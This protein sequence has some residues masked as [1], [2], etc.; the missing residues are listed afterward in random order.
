[1][2]AICSK[3]LYALIIAT[4]LVTNIFQAGYAAKLHDDPDTTAPA[5]ITNVTAVTGSAE[6]TI[7]LSWT[8]PGDD[9]AT[10]TAAAYLV[11]Y[12]NSA[13][14]D[15]T[16]WEAATVVSTGIPAPTG[17][18]A[19][20]SMT[21]TGLVPGATYYFSIRA[22]DE[23]P[24][25]AG[26]SNSPGAAAQ[27]PPPDTTA[28]AAITDLAAATGTETGSIQLTWT[29]PGDDDA[30]GTAGDYLV[31]YST[32]II[33]SQSAWDAAT[34]VSTGVPAPTEAGASQSM[35]VASLTPGATYYFAIRARDEVP[36]LGNMSNSPSAA[37]KT[38][39]PDTTAPA[40]IT[41]LVAVTGTD[42]GTIQ[43][44][45]TAPGDDEDSGTASTYII[46]YGTEPIDSQSAWDAATSVIS[47]VPAPTE[48][49]TTQSATVTGLMPGDSYH[50][51]IRTRDENFN[52]SGI[53]NDA[54]A[55]ART[56]TPLAVGTY[57][58]F[59]S[60]LFYIGAWQS[61]TTQ[62]PL[63]YYSGSYHRSANNGERVR[64]FVNG[65]R[66]AVQYPEYGAVLDV[67]VDGTLV[68]S[69]TQGDNHTVQYKKGWVSPILN[70]G[71]HM[72][73][74][75]HNG[76][77][78]YAYLDAVYVIS[79]AQCVPPAPISN[80]AATAGSSPES[81]VLTWTA[82]G[83][84]GNSGTASKYNIR[85][86]SNPIVTEDDWNNAYI[87][88]NTLT[89]KAAGQIESITVTGLT[90]L[91]A[92][93]FAVRAQDGETFPNIGGLS[94]TPSATASAPTLAAIGAY[95]YSNTTV[96]R[97]T[98]S[99]NSGDSPKIGNKVH[100]TF[101]GARISLN[102]Y[103]GTTRGIVAVH[104]DGVSIDTINQ[105]GTSSMLQSWTS[106]TLS[107][108]THVVEFIHQTGMYVGV[109]S[110]VVRGLPESIPPATISL[111]AATGTYDEQVKLTWTAPGDNDMTGT[112]SRYEIRYSRNPILTE[113]DWNNAAIYL[114]NGSSLPLPKSAGS[115]ETILVEKITPIVTHYFAIRA[116]D[117]E[118]TPN[119]SNISNSPGA[120]SKSPTPVGAAII[121]DPSLKYV[122]SWIYTA[123]GNDTNLY[124]FNG[125]DHTSSVIGNQAHTVINGNQVVL[126]YTAGSN[127]GTANMLIDGVQFA[128]I[129]EYSATTKHQ[130]L[131]TSATFPSGVHLI[132]FV[133]A[134]GEK[135]SID[136]LIVKNGPDT[137]PPARI[138]SL[139]ATFGGGNGV[140]MLGWSATG[141]DGNAGRAWRYEVR[142]SR[143]PILTEEDWNNARVYPN[144]MSP[145]AF[146]QTES[147]YVYGLT[148]TLR[149]YFAVKAYDDE[150]PA[151][152][153]AFSNVANAIAYYPT[154]VEL[155]TYNSYPSTAVKCTSSWATENKSGHYSDNT[156]LSSTTGQKCYVVFHG[157][158]VTAVFAKGPQ[159]G[160]LKAVI[161]GDIEDTINQYSADEQFQQTWTSPLLADTDYH[162][163]EFINET[164]N[165]VNLDAVTILTSDFTPPAAITNLTAAPKTIG[166]GI[167]LTW[168]APG[169]N[170]NAG[171]AK[172]YLVRMSTSPIIDDDSWNNAT[173]VT[174]NVPSPAAAGTTQSMDV[175]YNLCYGE[176]Y[177]LA[178]RTKDEVPNISPISNSS[179][180]MTKPVV[181]GDE[182]ASSNAVR[183]TGDWYTLYDTSMHSNSE[184]R[185]YTVGNSARVTYQGTGVSV[186]FAKGAIYGT[187][188]VTI[189]G[190]SVGMI[191]QY[192]EVTQSGQ[193]WNGPSQAYGLHTIEFL[194]SAGTYV[195]LDAIVVRMDVPPDAIT[196]L[197]TS[198]QNTDG[199]TMLT[200]TS[201]AAYGRTG[202][203]TYYLIRYSTS[204]IDS[205]AAWELATAVT[206]AV[207]V[208][209]PGSDQTFTV[210]G[211][212]PG[213]RYYFSVRPAY[214]YSVIVSPSIG[215]LS[216]TPGALSRG[217]TPAPAGKYDDTNPSWTYIGTWSSSTYPNGPFNNTVH[218]TTAYNNSAKI[219]IIGERFRLI[220]TKG[221]SQ[222]NID[223]YVDGSKVAS[224]N[225]NNATTLW[226][227]K[228][229]YIIPSGPGFHSLLFSHL[230]DNGLTSTQID[231][232]EVFTASDT[233]APG[234]VSN[235]SATT[236]LVSGSIILT[237]TAPGDDNNDGKAT[238]Y[239]VKYSLN[240]IT[241]TTTWNNAAAIKKN[242]PSPANAGTSQSAMIPDLS[243]GLT[244]YFAIRALDDQ[245]NVGEM[246]NSPSAS[247]KIT[248][249]GN[250]D[251]NDLN[252]IDYSR[253]WTALYNSKAVNGTYHEARS[254]KQLPHAE[255]KFTGS[256]IRLS[257]ASSPR[258]GRISVYI[259]GNFITAI[260]QYSNKVQWQ[261]NWTSPRL[262]NGIHK[263][264]LVPISGIVNLDSIQI[265]GAPDTLPPA[266]IA[267]LTAQPG[268]AVGS[269]RLSF[270][271]PGDDDMTGTATSYQVRYSPSPITDQ[272][273][274]EHATLPSSAIPGPL[275]AGTSQSFE[276]SGLM[277]NA[278]Y[279]FAIR[280]MDE[281]ENLAPLS[282][283]P[284]AKVK[285][286]GSNPIGDYE[287]G[288]PAFK[289]SGRWTV[290]NHA[291][292]SG[293]H[294]HVS[295]QTNDT[296]EFTFEG[297]QFNLKY[298]RGPG[299]GSMA[300]VVDGVLLATIKETS[301]PEQW[302]AIW[303]S[304]LL[305]YGSHTVRF[306][307]SKG[308]MVN[309]DA[310]H[311]SKTDTSAP[312]AITDLT[313]ASGSTDGSVDLSW[314]APGDD[315]S[316]G[317][318]ISY[319][320]R[321][322]SAP[323]DNQAAWNSATIVATGIPAPA[324]G[325]TNQSMTVTGLT[326]GETYYFA[327]RATDESAN[328]GEISNS[329]SAP[330]Q[331][332]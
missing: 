192:S 76:S 195:N 212:W 72:V 56:P 256:R 207:I 44:S 297:D 187:I 19:S 318:T 148:P 231:G 183:I 213:T 276:L 301:L 241:D 92:Q 15:E 12:G 268:T 239:Q 13:I 23:V 31:R 128:E 145:K 167:T 104:I 269:V 237:W 33:D 174:V 198:P 215:G 79:E 283:S 275:A 142:Y 222:R 194:H 95:N 307:H 266:A 320:I 68:G 221:P 121:D 201:P 24:N 94:N 311:I 32:T 244:Y 262:T 309:I 66:F 228:W 220:Y 154:P 284:V 177:Y 136:G 184:L 308:S 175:T 122:R 20:Q 291:N 6:G 204:P 74:L 35:T 190:S 57:D 134:S 55:L 168:T 234:T 138:T 214:K 9:D 14:E 202:H 10:G 173:P 43:L 106:P 64:F 329:P 326:P 206:N 205:E 325:G 50:F 179:S 330:A 321:Y 40:A 319:E 259:D 304:P 115:A 151:N 181:E 109:N 1:M 193:I 119:V 48:A 243:P 73:E 182:E 253:A 39:P 178:I 302:Q 98:G 261:K 274:W 306:V 313:A 126:I 232:I 279:Y 36:N 258:Y 86:S 200:W 26:L 217:L 49:G 75:V 191:D 230:G 285:A 117:D 252:T 146:G 271:A 34:P 224:I 63:Y 141:D 58:D 250:Y 280:A 197:K 209:P 144:I 147:L 30:T 218:S 225:A 81:I 152:V 77:S 282:N 172:S 299:Y 219:N 277:P 158:W 52:I 5:A 196:N 305:A 263:M 296:A 332:S 240:P 8:A 4:L 323:I 292:A 107:S 3:F 265:Y 27:T 46:R 129:N 143:N 65:I 159:Y 93:Y 103:T 17:A 18:G 87:F 210:T 161:D 2:K 160:N 96:F 25:L 223:V 317:T 170:D 22:Q 113:T 267:D 233:T 91:V 327:V 260:N 203:A 278:A 82:P 105:Y 315:D 101:N 257:Y 59:N 316:T 310:I 7:E 245:D 322:S 37:A 67:L 100:I 249:Q 235:L 166:L 251:D 156:F 112:A 80:L 242:I 328:T 97:Y 176:T 41:D 116:Y 164:G 236:G 264:R 150:E 61:T 108:G 186:V 53:S 238:Q 99:W 51:A 114:P 290:S 157:G 153:S 71:P 78:S 89:P 185:S 11:R 248:D 227:Q 254:A 169:D 163:V 140:V 331:S 226:Q 111:T 216:N 288:S 270:T 135:I 131:W 155:G 314:T 139:T 120:I 69:I 162:V 289:Y 165:L 29:A 102:Y 189:D 300:V 28:P 211:L 293:G 229:D 127:K 188:G 312:A 84:D 303:T 132:E 47:G 137:T 54:S 149:Y 281:E 123:G 246:S 110:I 180:T 255:V 38:N 21:V 124:P 208:Q 294:M 286:P 295:R 16:A 199:T 90:P 83:A 45:W 125:T 62:D 88:D 171:T 70:P 324:P 118:P 42:T 247:A 272:A 287:D 60:G 85:F 130:Q 133:H 273:S 298:T